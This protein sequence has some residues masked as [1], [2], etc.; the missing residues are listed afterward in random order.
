LHV[1]TF[2]MMTKML[3][4]VCGMSLDPR[5]RGE[6]LRI[7]PLSNSPIADVRRPVDAKRYW[8]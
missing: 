1:L 5:V 3:W 6:G 7:E 8:T 4:G 2:V